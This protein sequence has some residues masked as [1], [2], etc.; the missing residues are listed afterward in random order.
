MSSVQQDSF[1][2]AEDKIPISQKSISI[3][4]S[5]GL[6]YNGGQRVVVEVP[7]TVEFI[8]PKESYLQF[9]V[10]LQLPTGATNPTY[11]Q[12]DETLGAQILLKDV[13]IYSGGAGKI[14]LE[15]YQD[16]NVLTNVKYTYETNDVIRAKR[17]LTEGSTCH[18]IKTRGNTGTTESH[19][20]EVVNNP[21]FENVSANAAGD[22]FDDANFKTVKVQLPINTGLFQSNKVL[23]TLLT[24]GLVLDIQLESGNRVYRQLDTA[25][26]NTKALSKPFFHGIDAAGAA[27]AENTATTDIY[28]SKEKNQ[29]TK[30]EHLPF[31]VGEKINFVAVDSATVAD[32]DT[33]VADV[34]DDF[35]IDE[36]TE[37]ATYVKLTFTG[38]GGKTAVGQGNITSG[39]FYIISESVGTDYS[40]FDYTISNVELVLQEL[41]MPQGYKSKM[42][43]MM[44]E[45][46]SMNYDFLSF[47]NFKYSQLASDRV[48]NIRLPLNMSRAKA[49]LSV[50]TDASV[51]DSATAI[52]GGLVG[53]GKTYVTFEEATAVSTSDK[54]DCSDKSGMVGIV[55]YLTN[56]QFFY[57]GKLNPSRRVN[58]SKTSSQVSISQ[59]PLIELEKALS[60]SNVVPYSFRDFNTNFVIGRALSLHNGVYDTRG[61]DFNLQLEYN[62]STVPTKNKLWCNF[63]SHLRRIEFRGEG[64][65]LQV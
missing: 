36:I 5:N 6:N 38:A 48:A 3:P 35:V 42:M 28:I 47:T 59:Q 45:G 60:M 33:L 23:P 2:T 24:E 34:T 49:I 25:R 54:R 1:W 53:E 19:M 57:D 63:V 56:Y 21:Y 62:E 39:D 64:I 13:R 61:R 4:S 51:Y 32:L 8:Q 17:A 58:C 14:L 43:S 44:K 30:R 50:P 29:I 65:S 52:T 41:E 12:L 11:L 16:Y 10:K 46:G 27:L 40:Q 37:D 18:S 31:C 26:F 9:D 20:N 55:D 22:V 7:S 15:E